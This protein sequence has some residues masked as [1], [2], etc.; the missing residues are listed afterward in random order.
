MAR[1]RLGGNSLSDL[2]VFG[3]RA[4]AYAATYAKESSEGVIS[5]DQIDDIVKWAWNPLNAEKRWN[6]RIRFK[7]N[8][9]CRMKCR[10]GRYRQNGK[11][12]I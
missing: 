9:T 2:L 10:I 12:I 5:E 7:F 3:Q 4:G 1:N 11:G 8:L 6:T